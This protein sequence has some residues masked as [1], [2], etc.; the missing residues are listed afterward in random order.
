MINQIGDFIEIIKRLLIKIE[1]ICFRHLYLPLNTD[2]YIYI[3][4][5]RADVIISVTIKNK[6]INKLKI[7]MSG[8]TAERAGDVKM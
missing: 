3:D 8:G 7:R 6:Q 2:I 5:K 1:T 4:R